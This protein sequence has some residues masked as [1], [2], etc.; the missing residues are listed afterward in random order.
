VLVDG[1]ITL[2]RRID[3]ARPR[4][5]GDHG[6]VQLRDRLLLELGVSDSAATTAD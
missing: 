1:R 3:L 6:F 5:R 2:D 4:D